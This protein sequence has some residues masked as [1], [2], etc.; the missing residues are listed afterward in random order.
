MFALYINHSLDQVTDA[1]T[2]VELSLGSG[3]V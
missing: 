3:L 2:V 1:G